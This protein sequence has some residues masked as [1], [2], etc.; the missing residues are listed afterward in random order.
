MWQNECNQ[1]LKMLIIVLPVIIAL[2]NRLGTAS[3]PTCRSR[4]GYRTSGT[5]KDMDDA[6]HSPD[7]G[8]PYARPSPKNATPPTQ[9]SSR[10]LTSSTLGQQY[11]NIVDVDVRR[12]GIPRPSSESVETPKTT[13]VEPTF[14]N[15]PSAEK[16]DR[17]E[18]VPVGFY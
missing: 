14:R 3:D 4:L 8:K 16:P 11:V 12:F 15:L 17:I 6:N 2:D 10:G 1:Y 9:L 5:I 18:Y 7:S 13:V